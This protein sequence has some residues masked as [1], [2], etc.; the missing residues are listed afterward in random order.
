MS[1]STAKLG[2]TLP[3]GGSTG[4]I[5]GDDPVDIDVLNQNF[6]EIDAAM[7]AQSV[8]STS[9]PSSPYNGQIIRES[10]TKRLR[11]YVEGTDTWEL[12]D[13][14]PAIPAGARTVANEAA[15]P[16]TGNTVGD[17]YFV[18]DANKIAVLD[19]LP[20]GWLFYTPVYS[21]L[22]GVSTVAATGITTVTFPVGKFSQAPNVQVTLVTAD[23]NVV[24][25]PYRGAVATATSF[26]VRIFTLGGGQIGG[27]VEWVATQATKDA[28]AG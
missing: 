8:A 27:T 28:S 7:G 22:R 24:A 12:A 26:A 25:V 9:R 15:L 3:A 4:T 5:P 16:A 1:S 11:V 2:L 17:I 19:T 13:I 23:G 21:E 10:D 14:P 6:R 18:E 20:N